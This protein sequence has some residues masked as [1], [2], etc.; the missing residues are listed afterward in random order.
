MPEEI[1]ILTGTVD[2]VFLIGDRTARIESRALTEKGKWEQ[3][4][5]EEER[6]SKVLGRDLCLPE[7]GNFFFRNAI[8][9]VTNTKV[10]GKRVAENSNPAWVIP[11]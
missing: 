10:G 6:D 8:P 2:E 9:G 1:E 11:D 4:L 7:G 5:K 3:V